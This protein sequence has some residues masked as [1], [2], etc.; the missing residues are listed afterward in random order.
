VTPLERQRWLG[1]LALAVALPLPLTGLAGWVFLAP[2]LAVAV[3]ALA[4]RR[5]LAAAPVWVENLV[6]PAILVAVVA[7]GGLRYGILRPL[8][9]LA[10]LLAAVRLPG[11]SQGL[12][13]RS[14]AGLLSLLGCASVASST[15]PSLAV[16]LV[17]VLVFLSVALGRGTLL[18]LGGRDLG[19]ARAERWP[20]G[21]LVAGTA[22]LAVLLA[23]PVF[24]LLPRLRSPFA[25]SPFG[26]VGV[27]GFR[28]SV[29]LHAIGEI[30]TSQQ[31]ALLVRF[32]A[33]A[34]ADAEWLRLTGAS[35]NTYRAGSWV[36][37]QTRGE[38]LA[39]GPN[40]V[41]SLG[42]EPATQGLHEAEITLVRGQVN[43]FLPAGAVRMRLPQRL[44]VR[45]D[46]LGTLRIPRGTEPPI[47]YSVWFSGSPRWEPAPGPDDVEVPE[48]LRSALRELGGQMLG[49]ARGETAR[50]AAIEGYLQ[51]HY[52]YALRTY[53]PVGEDPV[54]WFLLRGRQGHCEFFAAAMTL[55]LRAQG[56][57]A[58]LQVGYMGGTPDGDGGFVV[59]DSHAHAW[60]LAWV[61]GG[62]RVF[63][64]T[65]P[66][67]Q[68][69]TPAADASATLGTSWQEIESAWDRWVL[70]FSLT[71]QVELMRSVAE[72]VWARRARLGAGSAV[73]AGLLAS[74]S[75]LRR[76]RQ[77]RRQADRPREPRGGPVSGALGRVMTA[78]AR[79]GLALP[80]ATTPAGF[81]ALARAAFPAAA[82]ALSWLVEA[83][84]RSC[85]AG[86]DGPG[87]SELRRRE[88]EI[89]RA[90]ARAGQVAAGRPAR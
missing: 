80:P 27:A 58:R 48:R 57:P 8:T 77:A 85:Y 28:N 40:G 81:A 67:G 5:V 83:H 42:A 20:P 54:M 39:A 21:R 53:A 9:Q 1:G 61:D 24:T 44:R 41:A 63:D 35:L 19:G 34:R 90:L 30:K 15:H 87:R 23:V 88:R 56:T 36:E 64:P 17:G 74:W 70:T 71:D 49:G 26:P 66:D 4:S 46:P 3:W 13:L 73:L 72:G 38:R 78:A 14:T 6:A 47:E 11:S 86:G 2:Y 7:S 65:P 75:W 33:A 68:P 89:L 50:A 52:S 16:Y 32:P 22:G 55:L 43:L 84:E 37:G 12:R 25:G 62:W 10:L 69:G 51:E 29:T 45:R 18:E 82:E 76:R 79:R 59:R 60:V 31:V